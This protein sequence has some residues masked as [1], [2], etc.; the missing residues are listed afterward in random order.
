VLCRFRRNACFSLKHRETGLFQIL[1][2]QQRL[3]DML[4]DEIFIIPG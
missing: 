2:D 3:S 1:K 4:A